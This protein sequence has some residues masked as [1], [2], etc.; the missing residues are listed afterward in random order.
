MLLSECLKQQG[1]LVCKES[2]NLVAVRA[3]DRLDFVWLCER[4]QPIETSHLD[5]S[6]ELQTWTLSPNTPKNWATTK[7]N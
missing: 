6:E 1:C 4:H 7:V 2:A 3:E 5:W